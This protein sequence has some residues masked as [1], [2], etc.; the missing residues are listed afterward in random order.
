MSFSLYMPFLICYHKLIYKYEHIQTNV[1]ISA[2]LYIWFEIF[3]IRITL[4]IYLNLPTWPINLLGLLLLFDSLMA[5]EKTNLLKNENNR[6]SFVFCIMFCIVSTL[7]AVIVIA[8]VIAT[9][10]VTRVVWRGLLGLC[11]L[12]FILYVLRHYPKGKL[13]TLT[14]NNQQ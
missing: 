13:P 7:F 9:A 3:C 12:I 5:V 10:I 6:E 11:T 4:H 8:T 14:I 1:Y 2:Y